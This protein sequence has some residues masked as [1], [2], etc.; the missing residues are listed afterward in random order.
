[1]SKEA[2]VQNAFTRNR[3]EELELDVWRE[4]V[5]PP[6][7]GKLDF[8]ES[9]KP[10]RII[11]GR[12][13]GKTMLLRYLSYHS[14]FS[15][16]RNNISEV[17]VESVGLYWRADTQ[18][19]KTLS[20]RGVHEDIW[21]GL[22]EHFLIIKIAME[23]V[24]SLIQIANSSSASLS[25]LELE[26]LNFDEFS[27]Y[28]SQ[29]RGNAYEL[30]K[31]LKKLKRKCEYCISNPHAIDDLEVIPSAFLRE[32]VEHVRNSSPGLN[33]TVFFVYIDEYEN[34]REYQQRV[35]NTKI[36]HSEPPL[37]YN[38]AMKANGMKTK[39][40]VG[41]ESI[42]NVHDYRDHNLDKYLLKSRDFE[43]FAAE[44]LLFRLSTVNG[45]RLSI[46][47]SVLKDPDKVLSRQE[48]AYRERVVAEAK[49]M[50][51]GRSSDELANNALQDGPIKKLIERELNKV[52]SDRKSNFTSADFY[53]VRHAKA[54]IVN[55]AL[56]NRKTQ[57]VSD[58]KGEF[59]KYINGE[60]SKYVGK[61][62]WIHNNFIGCYLRLYRPF[63]RACPYYAGFETFAKLSKGN[64]RHFLELVRACAKDIEQ[65]NSSELPTVEPEK[66][67][68]AA[69]RASEE[70]LS[71]ID[72]FGSLG[73]ILSRFVTELGGI[74][75]YAHNRASQ[76]EPEIN[77]F[78]VSDDNNKLNAE[79]IGFFNE[80]E[81][82][83]VLSPEK[84]TK[85]KGDVDL[86]VKEYVL[87]PI[88]SPHFLLSYA[89]KRKISLTI[90]QVKT[91]I[92]GNEDERRILR[93]EFKKRY[94]SDFSE[95]ENSDPRMK[96]D[97]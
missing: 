65:V 52:L 87:N 33:K 31:S 25:P 76:S 43:L 12:G 13:C 19:L 50:L 91:L 37:I 29:I 46:D 92:G 18:F 48:A 7:Y 8:N 96:L 27:D 67:A 20:G 62:N 42:S 40:T 73:I 11:G 9:N 47:E 74:F 71:E 66:Q 24:E 45:L 36:K 6:F 77:H 34:L 2:T 28:N 84:S 81:K 53:S 32:M 78:S 59:N 23:V 80:A 69:K 26:G 5:V 3:A 68:F 51:P 60:D 16:N 49:I 70:L 54:T 56:L 4:F 14:K 44:I 95:N 97:L 93:S 15:I 75:S 90:E 79:D 88:Y 85:E 94:K 39:Q 30:K 38:I 41:D 61:A 1:M 64:L 55:I 21:E 10:K 86:S 58:I 17:E 35:I 72:S 82:W 22:F 89:K 57:K 63:S 83:G